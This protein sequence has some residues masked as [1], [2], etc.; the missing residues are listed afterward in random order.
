MCS[1]LLAETEFRECAYRPRP[2]QNLAHT[3]PS[4]TEPGVLAHLLK[5]VSGFFQPAEMTALVRPPHRRNR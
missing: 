1:R 4:N 5:Y 2:T 3:V